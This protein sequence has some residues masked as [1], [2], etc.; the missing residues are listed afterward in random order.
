M[1][2][3]RQRVRAFLAGH[4]VDR[5][6]NGL[7]GC[8]TAGLHNLAYHHLK[9]VLGVDDPANRIATFMT[10]AVFEP[11]V[12]DAMEGDL[13]LLGSRM[14]PSP[15]W[16]DESAGQWQPL[17]LWG[18]QVQ[19]A[20]AWQFRHEADGSWWW[21]GARCPPGGLYFDAPGGQG[22]TADGIDDEV[23]SPDDYHPPHELPEGLLASLE[24][25]ARWL[26]ENTDYAICSGEVIQDLQL[27]PGGLTAWWSRLLAD[28]PA[29]HAFLAK[30]VEAAL[31]QL[32]QLDQ[33]IGPYVEILGIADDMGDTRGI[34]I[35]PDRW[36]DIYRPHYQRLF[37]EW[38]TITR[39]KANL[40]TCGAMAA[41]LPD[42]AD[43]GVDLYNPVQTSADGMAPQS[44]RDRVGDRLI[45]YGGAYDAV[46][47]AGATAD[48]VYDRVRAD[49]RALGRG[50]RYLF[51][52][53]HNLPGDMPMAHLAAMLAAYRDC[54]SD[55]DLQPV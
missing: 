34:T 20:R 14:C 31:A 9:Q 46:S 6:P 48:Q 40:H 43:C 10:N 29:C 7:G 55:P 33:A 37:S 28:P 18:I 16:G 11:T 19:A 27:K 36:R 4:A 13:V 32:R 41:I 52:G 30:A 21:G 8:E 49:I 35:G 5:I 3:P 24:R 23:L 42:L 1:M 22:V 38:H 50:G 26:Y 45:L 54:R 44:L 15:F 53:V 2:T 51:A 17:R 12:L 25:Q 47:L 39:M